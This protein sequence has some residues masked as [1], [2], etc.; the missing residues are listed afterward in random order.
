[1]T[2]K[3]YIDS[4]IQPLHLQDTVNEA[5]DVFYSSKCEH[6]PVLSDIGNVE[7]MFSYDNLK[8]A[9]PLLKLDNIFT[10]FKPNL[11]DKDT[12]IYKLLSIAIEAELDTLQ[13]VDEKKVYLGCI[14]TNLLFLDFLKKLGLDKSGGIIEVR[15]DNQS[16]S[17]IAKIVESEHCHI[18]SIFENND[19]NGN[20]SFILKVDADQINYI[21]LALERYNYEVLS[22]FSNHKVS[23]LEKERL[24]HLLR[25]INI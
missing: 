25:Y 5:L 18:V 6:L 16:I 17:E 4:N 8:R 11:V 7:C 3:D 20:K 13:V 1:M 14:K 10:F 15:K 19:L 9:D 23:N 22:Y 12:P 2:A 24:D 21:L